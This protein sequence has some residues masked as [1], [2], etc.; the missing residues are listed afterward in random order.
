MDD[1]PLVH[2]DETVMQ[3]IRE[4]CLPLPEA[5]EVLAF[6]APSFQVRAKKFVFMHAHDE[7]VAV[8]CKAEPGF[9]EA[10]VHTAPE[11]YFRPPYLGG[12]GWIA[13]WV[14]PGSEP[15]WDEVSEI[16]H[17][18]YRLIAPKRLS[19]LLD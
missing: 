19:R 13:M 1:H 12:R 7:R 15:D 17:I 18:S 4:I 8:W 9:Q 16:I 3:E 11:R 2:I 5:E 14:D 6:G 10:M